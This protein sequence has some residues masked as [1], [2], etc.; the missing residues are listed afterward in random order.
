MNTL[1]AEVDFD[2]V[3]NAVLSG[4]LSASWDSVDDINGNLSLLQITIN[5]KYTYY[6]RYL[7]V[8]EN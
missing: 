4:K 1:Q 2:V 6:Y 3:S 5:A 7:G 8:I